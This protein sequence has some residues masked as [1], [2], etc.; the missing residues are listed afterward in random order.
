MI[1]FLWCGLLV[2]AG[3]GADY[4]V[5]A[6]GDDANPGSAERPWRTIERVNRC[7]PRP[8]DR[9]LLEGGRTF[10]GTLRLN[11]AFSKVVVSSFGDGRAVVDGG[12]GRAVS[13]EGAK[14]LA[15]RN[16]RLIGSGRKTGNTESGLVVA[17]AEEVEISDV[18][19][20]GFRSSGVAITGSGGVRVLRVHAHENGY[21]GISSDGELSHDLYVAHCLVENNPGDPTARDNHSGNGIV[22]GRTR[23]AIIESCEARYNGWD[24]PWT[25]NGPVGIWTFESDHVT[26][27]FCVAHHNRSTAT[28]GGGFDFDGGMTNSVLQYNYSH[29][30]FGSGYLICQ[31]D[32]AGPFADNVVRYNISQDDGLKAHDAGIYVWVGGRGMKGALVHNNTIFNNK[33]SAVAFDVEKKFARPAP[34]M[35]FYNNIF[36]SLGPQIRGGARH[37]RFVGNL[38]WSMG[39]RGFLVDGYRD[40]V[41][42]AAATGQEVSGDRLAGRFADPRLRKDGT[43]LLTDPDALASLAEYLLLPGSP[44]IDAGVDLRERF[45]IDP[46]KRDFYGTSLPQ[47][48]GFDIGAAEFRE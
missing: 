6:K 30:N 31:Y 8:G 14:G 33:G 46:G 7:E 2:S 42:W 37:G 25:G 38:Y 34:E 39:E 12:N 43:G 15:V 3:F 17:H 20:S 23:G 29:D 13:I 16:L 45:G 24:M 1:R 21:A 27:Q 18:E 44:A 41:K 40:F 19:V 36:V 5:G 47:G 48:R 9:I 11:A 28:D 35:R 26:I 10:R 4:Y 32:G 22:I